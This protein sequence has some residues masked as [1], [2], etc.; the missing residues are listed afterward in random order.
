MGGRTAVSPLWIDFSAKR[1]DKQRT[2]RQLTVAESLKSVSAD[3][4]VAYRMQ[5]GK[6]QWVLYRSLD[7]PGNRTFLGQN[8]SSEQVVGRFDPETGTLDEFY[9]IEADDE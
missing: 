4:A 3:V 6:D 8:Y 7:D 5:S 9:E 1:F 2:W